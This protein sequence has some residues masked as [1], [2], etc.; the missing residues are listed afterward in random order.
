MAFMY[1]V[2]LDIYLSFG[3]PLGLG[4]LSMT[5][6]D[7]DSELLFVSPFLYHFI[8]HCSL[9][10]HRLNMHTCMAPVH[11]YTPRLLLSF[12]SFTKYCGFLVHICTRTC[13][14][15]LPFSLLITSRRLFFIFAPF[16]RLECSGTS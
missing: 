2:T 16:T 8:I 5:T 9:A 12:V 14:G 7:N 6:T 11:T 10:G 15:P 1:T 3:G 4:V 13:A